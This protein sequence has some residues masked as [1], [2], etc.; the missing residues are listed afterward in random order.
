MAARGKQVQAHAPGT[1]D[2][3]SCSAFPP[4]AKKVAMDV[5][6]FPQAHSML[7]VAV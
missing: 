4:G 5:T 7:M 3:M 1:P 2:A 6:A